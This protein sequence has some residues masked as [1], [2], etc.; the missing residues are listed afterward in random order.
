MLQLLVSSPLSLVPFPVVYC[1]RWRARLSSVSDKSRTTNQEEG[2]D[3]RH[4]RSGGEHSDDDGDDNVDTIPKVSCTVLTQPI[5]SDKTDIIIDS[6]GSHHFV[7]NS[8]YFDSPPVPLQHRE[9][10]AV[11]NGAR[12]Q[13]DAWARAISRRACGLCQEL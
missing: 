7:H 11:A 8:S 10:G 13:I 4:A 9:T 12:E 1:A 5:G 2:K 3:A 6:G